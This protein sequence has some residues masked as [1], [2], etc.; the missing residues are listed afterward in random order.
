MEMSSAARAAV[1]LGLATL[2]Q[3]HLHLDL[4]DAQSDASEASL[5]YGVGRIEVTEPCGH[6][7]GKLPLGMDHTMGTEDLYDGPRYYVIGRPAHGG[8]FPTY[9]FNPCGRTRSTRPLPRSRRGR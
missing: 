9:T 5:T 3:F 6:H 4:R 8:R 2:A 7:L 1:K